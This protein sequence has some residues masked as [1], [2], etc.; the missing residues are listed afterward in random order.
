MAADVKTVDDLT[1]LA[2]QEDPTYQVLYRE[3]MGGPWTL[4]VEYEFETR[5]T[6]LAQVVAE[7]DFFGSMD[8]V[9][10]RVCVPLLLI[11]N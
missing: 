2:H 9:A 8:E 7:W 5:E 10:V 6:A 11:S 1:I 3:T 4:D